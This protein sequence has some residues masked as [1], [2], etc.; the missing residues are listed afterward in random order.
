MEQLNLG[1]GMQQNYFLQL[2]EFVSFL[3]ILLPPIRVCTI[4]RK[5][6]NYL[7][8]VHR[9][10]LKHH[11]CPKIDLTCLNQNKYTESHI[12]RMCSC[13]NHVTLKIN[14]LVFTLLVKQPLHILLHRGMVFTIKLGVH[15]NR[16]K[17]GKVVNI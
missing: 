3:S 7:H 9:R 5:S 14:I 6:D 11:L 16:R 15:M 8:V 13:H 1:R 12:F 17:S 4:F 2:S 10:K